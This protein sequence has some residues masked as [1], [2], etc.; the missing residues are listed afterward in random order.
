MTLTCLSKA[1]SPTP[2]A[3]DRGVPTAVVSRLVSLTRAMA[4]HGAPSPGARAHLVEALPS[5]FAADTCAILEDARFRR[6]G[7]GPFAALEVSRSMTRDAR[8]WLSDLAERDRHLDPLA[9]P[10][11]GVKEVGSVVV[12]RLQVALR[13]QANRGAQLAPGYAAPAR[14]SD[15]LGSVLRR[16]GSRVERILLFR[17]EGATPF[18]VADEQALCALHEGLGP[19][20]A[21][22]IRPRSLPPRVQATF[23]LLLSGL[24]D[25]E[26]AERL[27]IS[28]HTVRQ[29]VKAILRA[30]GVS[31][32]GRLIASCRA[33]GDRHLSA[34]PRRD[35]SGAP[36]A[37]V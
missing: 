5:V 6:D 24:A 32:R 7:R 14:F 10:A 27:A 26:I 18:T 19:L 17:A 34:R 16:G 36:P 12:C 13:D 9:A 23:D 1:R 2:T 11:L 20:Y 31:G 30:Y 8:V 15:V 25:K 37:A 35:A 33:P 28:H 4:D 22:P 21:L 3:D 29:Y